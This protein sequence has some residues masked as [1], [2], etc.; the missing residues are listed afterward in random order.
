LV[1]FVVAVVIVVFNFIGNAEQSK[2]NEKFAAT[3]VVAEGDLVDELKVWAESEYLV[4]LDD[5]DAESVLWNRLDSTS[6]DG[7]V[8]LD[9]NS[10]VL[11]K[12]VYGDY[13]GVRLFK[14]SDGWQL[15]VDSFEEPVSAN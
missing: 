4:V 13:V 11:V 7:S 6:D 1:V 5:N 12:N 8:F 15:L 10:S 2:F 3:D 9:S 14:D